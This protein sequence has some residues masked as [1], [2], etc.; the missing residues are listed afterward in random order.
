[1]NAPLQI[2][3]EVPRTEAEGPGLRYAI[4]VQGCPLRCPG[5]CNP[6]FLPFRP[7]NL[8][9]PAEILQDLRASGVEGLS[10]LGGEPF[11]QAEALAEVARGAQ[12]MG[13]NVM[14]Y[15]GYTLEQLREEDR[16]GWAALLD[17]TDLLVDGPYVEA[18]RTTE[19]RWIGSENQR[20]HFLTDALS[21]ADLEGRNTIEIRIR[22]GEVVLN[23]WPLFGARTRLIE[24]PASQPALSPAEASV[25]ATLDT[26]IGKAKWPPPP[27]VSLQ[28]PSAR[29]ASAASKRIAAACNE[30]L[31]RE[32]VAELTVLRA[33]RRLRGRPWDESVVGRFRPR[34]TEATERIWRRASESLKQLAKESTG[35]RV[36]RRTVRRWI[37][38]GDT[39]SG[40]WILYFLFWRH[41]ASR[42]GLEARAAQDRLAKGS[43]LVALA[44][45]DAEALGGALGRLLEGPTVHVLERLEGPL[46]EAWKHRVAALHD[47][48][49]AR[50]VGACL[51]LYVE[52]LR[53]AGRLDLLRLP[54]RLMAHLAEGEDI[55]AAALARCS[56]PTMEAQQAERG[57]WAEFYELAGELEDVV[58]SLRRAVYGE[59]EY[60]QAQIVLDD[61]ASSLGPALPPLMGAAAALRGRVG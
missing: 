60:E 48:D 51:R 23:G 44:V 7:A 19:R 10:L 41:A 4:W 53:G 15:T 24:R 37:A 5:C 9:A 20:T 38:I 6:E 25:L 39:D 61:Y 12:A 52:R 50:R 49:D 3:L 1:M 32:G 30:L 47:A 45:L 46:L 8:R 11:A 58:A 27:P 21:P 26:L 28:V 2:A 13:L 14:I 59:P 16:P 55:V 29:L 31:V 40:D 22:D 43:P 17:H 57:A 33:G 56:G 18:L 36:K 35:E 42:L 54:M 34:Y